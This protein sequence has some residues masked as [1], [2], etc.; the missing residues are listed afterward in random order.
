MA[1]VAEREEE[2]HCDRVG[3]DVVERLEI[4]REQLAVRSH[5]LGDTGAELER[6]ERRGVVDARPV[7]IGARLPPEVKQVLEAG[8]R[9]E[10]RSCSPPLEQCIRR[11]RRPVREAID[12]TGARAHEL[13]RGEH[14]LLLVS[15]AVGTF[16]VRIVPSLTSTASVNVPPTSI[17]SSVAG[18]R[19]R[20]F[21]I[22]DVSRVFGA[23]WSASSASVSA[24]AP[25]RW[26]CASASARSGSAPSAVLG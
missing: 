10:R 1:R 15:A 4:E 12:V 9:H 11:D 25:R 6:N 20:A 16:A 5:P 13:R 22:R 23:S 19:I 2:A 24:I 18:A 8:G 14:G 3:V 26:S 17:P 21:S 7:E